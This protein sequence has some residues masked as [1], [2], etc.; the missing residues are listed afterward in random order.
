MRPEE[1]QEVLER[2]G[3]KETQDGFELA[4]RGFQKASKRA[5]ELRKQGDAEATR[6]LA[7]SPEDPLRWEYARC[8]Q[9]DSFAAEVH[10]SGI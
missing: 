7:L 1:R 5:L 6:I 9:I 3:L 2:H 10:R 4:M 8:I